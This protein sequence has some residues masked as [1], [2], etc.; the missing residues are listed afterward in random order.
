MPRL[1]IRMLYKKTFSHSNSY[2]NSF[3][4]NELKRKRSG[5]LNENGVEPPNNGEPDFP[6]PHKRIRGNWCEVE[7]E[8]ENITSNTTHH[9]DNNIIKD[10]NGPNYSGDGMDID[11]GGASHNGYSGNDQNYGRFG[12]NYTRNNPGCSES[13]ISSNGEGQEEICYDGDEEDA[14]RKSDHMPRPLSGLIEPRIEKFIEELEINREHDVSP[15]DHHSSRIEFK[16]TV[17]HLRDKYLEEASTNLDI[18]VTEL[19]LKEYYILTGVVSI[20]KNVESNAFETW[21]E[22]Q[23]LFGNC[24]S[25]FANIKAE[26]YSP[27]KEMPLGNNLGPSTSRQ[28][29]T[30]VAT[31]QINCNERPPETASCSRDLWRS[32]GI[33]SKEILGSPVG[34]Y[35]ITDSNPSVN[36]SIFGINSY[37]VEGASIKSDEPISSAEPE[38]SSQDSSASNPGENQQISSTPS[39]S[40]DSDNSLL[41]PH[42]NDNIQHEVPAENR[43]VFGRRHHIQPG[44]NHQQPPNVNADPDRIGNED[45]IYD[46]YNRFIIEDGAAEARAAAAR[47]PAQRIRPH[48]WLRDQYWSEDEESSDEDEPPVSTDSGQGDD[49]DDAEEN[50]E[51]V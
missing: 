24:T 34:D 25:Q 32:D 22:I 11:E 48:P 14:T 5:H 40:S 31:E 36:L 39:E 45:L 10:D 50:V 9:G 7:N 44:N 43:Q 19:Y 29:C 12:L 21:C 51:G 4:S 42:N 20:Q 30:S 33:Q 23:F 27:H 15:V 16:A 28:E 46:A 8:S 2:L 18:C 47:N 38:N 37:S 3:Q 1:E 13:D 26:Q 49:L 35:S 41:Q 6:R 17:D